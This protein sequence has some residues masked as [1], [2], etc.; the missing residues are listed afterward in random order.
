MNY[1]LEPIDNGSNY[2]FRDKMLKAGVS[3]SAFPWDHDCVF[4]V[5]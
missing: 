3:R 2:P 5:E 4:F 1:G